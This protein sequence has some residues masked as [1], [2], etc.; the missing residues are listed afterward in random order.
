M[1]VKPLMLSSFHT[2]IPSGR[3]QVSQRPWLNSMPR[4]RA[5]RYAQLG[6]VLNQGEKGSAF[7][8]N[9]P[10]ARGTQQGTPIQL[11]Q[12]PHEFAPL[13][14]GNCSMQMPW[15]ASGQAAERAH[16]NQSQ[17]CAAALKAKELVPIQSVKLVLISGVRL[18]LT[19][20][21]TKGLPE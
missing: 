14:L 4:K 11:K 6:V 13:Q 8:C 16:A 5:P 21:A 15:H 17:R 20:S 18:L 19:T 7:Q 9:K 1:Q 3:V 10:V 2:K 12:T